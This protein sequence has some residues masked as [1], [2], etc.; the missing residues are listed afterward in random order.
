MS[1]KKDLIKYTP[2]SEQQ[3]A[4]DFIIQTKKE[5][6]DKKFFLMNMPVGVGKSH[7]GLMIADWY[8][9]KI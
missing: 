6:P 5:D 2:R 3:D 4:L 1:L 7:L 9:S 8:T